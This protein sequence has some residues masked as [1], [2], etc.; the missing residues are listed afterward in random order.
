[1]LLIDHVR[2]SALVEV[3]LVARDDEERLLPVRAED[4]LERQP[5]VARPLRVDLEVA[6][7]D[8]LDVAELLAVRSDDDAAGLGVDG[9]IGVRSSHLDASFGEISPS[10]R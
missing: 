6:V 10:F 5:V 4:L 2:L 1:M 8:V 9:S 3:D 7:L